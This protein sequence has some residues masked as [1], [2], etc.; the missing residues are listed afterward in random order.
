MSNVEIT[1]QE[2]IQKA[3][4]LLQRG[5]IVAIPTETVYGLAA[6]ATNDQAVKAV[7]AAKGRPAHNPLIVHLPSA[8]H[9]QR[10]AVMTPI[11]K[12][13]AKVFWPGPLTMILQRVPGRAL[14]PLTT[15]GLDTVAIRVPGHA[16]A[17][18]ILTAA[19]IPL[20][21]PSANPSGALSPTRPD[22]VAAALGD[23][24]ALVIDDG[25]T[26][27]GIESTIVAAYDA[28]CRILR[29]GAITPDDISRTVQESVEVVASH[30]TIEAPGM[31]KRHY[32]P[33][34]PLR[35]NAQAA[36]NNE[37]FLAFGTHPKHNHT[38]TLWLSRAGNLAEAAEN[39]YH[40]LH[41][42]DDKG[43]DKIA[44]SPIPNTGIGVAIN[45]RLKRATTP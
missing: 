40:M 7:Y 10:Y 15:A 19:G 16:V 39:L 35:L 22:H 6:D 32:A 20:A 41:Q 2:T 13:L 28:R 42:L 37:G 11:A 34:T 12:K 36:L 1:S 44:I 21:A 33:R 25:A 5:A 31:E 43:C 4:E 8:D 38:P 27:H 23:R 45:D 17:R 3:A 26:R 14:S 30:P 29:P 9:V 24:V 18:N